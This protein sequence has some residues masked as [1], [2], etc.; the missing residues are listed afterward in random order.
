MQT[1]ANFV[2]FFLCCSVKFEKFLDKC[3]IDY[4]NV[5]YFGINKP[6]F[7]ELQRIQNAAS[8]TVVELYKYDHVGNTLRDLHWL[9][10]TQRV[11]YNILL[12]VFKCLNSFV[13]LYSCLHL[14]VIPIY[15]IKMSI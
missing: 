11:K 7:L 10:V 8:K 13:P 1:E 4:C 3:K 2:R 5:L 6:A 12:L 14:S 15:L 9:P